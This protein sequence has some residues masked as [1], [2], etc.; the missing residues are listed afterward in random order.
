VAMVLASDV[1]EEGV[2]P[3]GKVNRLIRRLRGT[4]R[5]LGLSPDRQG[6]GL[7]DAGAATD[8]AP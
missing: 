8:A 2:S 7:I 4:A 1:L 6:A 5:D 3:R